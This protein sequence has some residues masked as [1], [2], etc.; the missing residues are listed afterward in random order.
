MTRV[1]VY[2]E[3]DGED[4]SCAQDSLSSFPFP[5]AYGLGNQT[6]PL[7]AGW[8]YG[9]GAGFLCVLYSIHL[10]LLSV[11]LKADLTFC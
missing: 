9:V 4:S 7:L 6:L 8:E 2:W 5:E 11:D 10:V 3:I 1:L